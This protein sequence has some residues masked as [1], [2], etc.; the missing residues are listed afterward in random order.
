MKVHYSDHK[1]LQSSI[2]VTFNYMLIV[3]VRNFYALALTPNW[4]TTPCWMSVTPYAIYSQL[5]SI[6]NLSRKEHE[7]PKTN[8]NYL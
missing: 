5:S 7:L 3:M 2:Y 8:G 1:S 6:Y 4:K